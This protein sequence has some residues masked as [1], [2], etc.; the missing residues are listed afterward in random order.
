MNYIIAYRSDSQIAYD[1]YRAKRQSGHWASPKPMAGPCA[2]T[3]RIHVPGGCYALT[4]VTGS[5]QSSD[6]ADVAIASSDPR[7]VPDQEVTLWMT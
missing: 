4:E 5:R 7:T 1:H 3:I 6:H 2:F